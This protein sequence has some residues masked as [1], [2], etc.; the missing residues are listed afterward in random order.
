M[1]ASRAAERHVSLSATG[2]NSVADESPCQR[3]LGAA[4]S[5]QRRR[6]FVKTWQI[7]SIKASQRGRFTLATAGSPGENTVSS[8]P[9]WGL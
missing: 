7:P 2:P 8:P 6:G 9:W 1:I 3:L 5:G 4:P